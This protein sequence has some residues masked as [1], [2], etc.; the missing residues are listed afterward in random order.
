MRSLLALAE[1]A[2]LRFALIA[3]RLSPL[4][5]AAP[6]WGSPLVPRQVRVYL[7]VLLAA[8]LFPVVPGSLPADLSAS[9]W[10]LALAVAREMLIGFLVAYAAVLL[11]AGAQ[12]AGQLIDIQIGFGVANVLDPLTSAQVTLVGQLQYM[13]ALMVFI[14]L[15]GHHLLLRGLADTFTVAPL[16]HPLAGIDSLALFVNRSARLMFVAG[17]QIAAPALT[18]LFLTNFALGLT[19]RMLPQMNIFMVGMPVNVGVGLLIFALGLTLFPA[20]WAG[21]QASLAELYR[22]LNRALAA[23][24]HG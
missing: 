17:A 22:G 16:G 19:A 12:L 5:M 4:M 7:V 11:F 15:D 20:V 9:V 2:V 10:S 3:A 8:V 23:T 13:L 21:S 24:G 6:V 1:P 14:L 18:A